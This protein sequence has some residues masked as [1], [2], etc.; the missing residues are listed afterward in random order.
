VTKWGHVTLPGVGTS[1]S[2]WHCLLQIGRT[3]VKVGS[4]KITST[5]YYEEYHRLI[6][7]KFFFKN[8]HDEAQNSC[9]VL[10]AIYLAR[11][12]LSGAGRRN[13]NVRA[14]AFVESRQPAWGTDDDGDAP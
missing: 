10:R 8:K 11:V 4:L 2:K 12:K 1:T 9:S 6:R 14:R 3:I 7:D 13:V 5:S